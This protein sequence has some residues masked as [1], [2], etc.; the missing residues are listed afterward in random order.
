MGD[1]LT[2]VDEDFGLVLLMG[3]VSVF[4]TEEI[5]QFGRS[6]IVISP[7]P[8]T[9]RCYSFYC[10]ESSL[11]LSV[12]QKAQGKPW[13]VQKP[14]F[15]LQ[16]KYNA[17]ICSKLTFQTHANWWTGLPRRRFVNFGRW[18]IFGYKFVLRYICIRGLPN[19]PYRVRNIYGCTESNRH[20]PWPKRSRKS[21]RWFKGF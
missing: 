1:V 21:I 7:C 14:P 8:C 19:F 2:S 10:I 3:R 5:M 12:L 11:S 16:K 15:S 13:W 9:N 6:S 20:S 18:K 17:S 4:L